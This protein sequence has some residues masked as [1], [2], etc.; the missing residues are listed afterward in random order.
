MTDPQQ[1]GYSGDPSWQA[2]PPAQPG[3]YQDPGYQ[4]MYQDPTVQ[5]A[6][7][8]QPYQPGY[9]ADPGYPTQAYPAGTDPISGQP[10]M[11]P[12][13]PP[14]GYP[15]AGYPVVTPGPSTNGLSIAAMVVAIVGA[16]GLCGYGLGGYLGAVGAIMGH[17]ASKQIRERGEGGSGF[18][19][20]GIIVGWISTAIAVLSTIAI[21]IFF[22]WLANQPSTY[23][24][25][26]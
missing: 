19:K 8:A 20:A 12:G 22:V 6:A 4:P 25:G 9:P 17:V 23:D 11:A 7:P 5:A 14:A 16:L 13:Y 10:V 2:Q 1:S 24:T 3:G 26:Y 18:A 15:P 21:V